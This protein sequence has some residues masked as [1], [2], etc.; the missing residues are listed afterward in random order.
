[1]AE[2]DVQKAIRMV[3]ETGKVEFGT[4]TGASI[5]AHGG[6]KL[7]LLAGNCPKALRDEIVQL[8]SKSGVPLKEMPFPSIELGGICGKPFPV[9]MLSIM[10]EGDSD[11]LALIKE[12]SKDGKTE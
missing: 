3:V 6:A 11:I 12:G 7:M 1:M 2:F 5:A 9:L 8:C 10:E 4:R